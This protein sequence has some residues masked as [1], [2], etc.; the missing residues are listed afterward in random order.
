MC[1]G[2][3][4]WPPPAF[5]TGQGTTG[6]PASSTTRQLQ[7]TKGDGIKKEKI[8]W[9]FSTDYGIKATKTGINLVGMS[10]IFN[11]HTLLMHCT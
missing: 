4:V 3:V 2:V 10:N 9:D 11:K 1:G 5:Q 6:S 7:Q 8:F